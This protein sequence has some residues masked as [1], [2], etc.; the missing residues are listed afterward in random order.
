VW[1][2]GWAKKKHS[3]K[4]KSY[5]SLCLG[6][7]TDTDLEPAGMSGGTLSRIFKGRREGLILK[8]GGGKGRK[9]TAF[10][11]RGV[12]RGLRWKSGKRKEGAMGQFYKL[13][14]ANP[15]KIEKFRGT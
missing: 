10:L 8:T 15:N 7:A 9:I 13:L 14:L 4:G 11:L 12:S 1:N 2:H 6:A 3:E 5:K